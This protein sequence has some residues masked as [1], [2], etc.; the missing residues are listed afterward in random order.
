MFQF[1]GNKLS[2]YYGIQLDN[3]N[4]LT[5]LLPPDVITY[6]NEKYYFNNI[7]EAREWYNIL[8]RTIPRRA[9]NST[10]RTVTRKTIPT[11]KQHNLIQQQ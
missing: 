10:R 9:K 3:N 11:N 5:P 7:I 6:N 1:L 2:Q 4:L 8:K